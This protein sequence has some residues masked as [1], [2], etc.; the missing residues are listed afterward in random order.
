MVQ[1]A[2]R[3]FTHGQ[4]HPTVG[5]WDNYCALIKRTD[6]L[7]GMLKQHL[8]A[9]AI[10]EDPVAFSLYLNL[11]ATEIF[12]H[13]SA[14]T[15]AEEEGLPSL[16]TAESQRR[17][18][19]AAFQISTAV[20]LNLPSPTT[21]KSDILMLQAIF[22]AWP[23]TMALKAFHRELTHEGAYDN[24]NGIVASSRLLLVALAHVE[25]SDGYWHRS[26]AHVESKLQELEEKN[27]FEA[28]SSSA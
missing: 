24:T 23:L 8:N 22:I 5:F 6:E 27:G 25:E 12:S 17:A 4:G 28:L 26:I 19:A 13:E 21:A 7:F 2:L 20:R 10:R 14:L 9:T 1:L 3:C 18:T 16:M 15:R 11:R